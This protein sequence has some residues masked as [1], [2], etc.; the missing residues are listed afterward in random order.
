[1]VLLWIHSAW[2]VLY[3]LEKFQIIWNYTTYRKKIKIKNRE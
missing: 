2:Q 1:V 3:M